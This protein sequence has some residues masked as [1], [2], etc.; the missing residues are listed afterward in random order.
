MEENRDHAGPTAAEGQEQNP[1]VE[2]GPIEKLDDD[3]TLGSQTPGSQK[4]E[5]MVQEELKPNTE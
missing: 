3:N 4:N 2:L 1:P 5:S